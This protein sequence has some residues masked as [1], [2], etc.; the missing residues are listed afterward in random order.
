MASMTENFALYAQG[1]I[2]TVQEFYVEPDYRSSGVG[3]NLMDAVK[4]HAKAHHWACIELCTPPLPQFNGS[5][6]FYQSQG[7]AA[8]G[9]RK[10]RIKLNTYGGT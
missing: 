6:C 5:L 10:M 4:A 1:K 7:L 2:G 9:G 8:V 3:A